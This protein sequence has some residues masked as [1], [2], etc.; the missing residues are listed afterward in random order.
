M[1]MV[2]H[3]VRLA[4]QNET[5]EIFKFDIHKIMILISGEMSNYFL[6]KNGN[7]SITLPSVS[8]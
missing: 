4:R 2:K 8:S 3:D 1:M 5:A 7:L 6:K